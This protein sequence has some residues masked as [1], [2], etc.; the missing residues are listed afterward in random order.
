M[1]RCEQSEPT[2]FKQDAPGLALKFPQQ[3]RWEAG[4]SSQ[5]SQGSHPG[6]CTLSEVHAKVTVLATCVRRVSM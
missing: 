4:R 2:V 6:W 5:T 1:G 3:E